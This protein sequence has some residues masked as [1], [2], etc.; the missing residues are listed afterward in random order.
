MSSNNFFYIFFAY[1]KVVMFLQLVIMNIIK[2]SYKRKPVKKN[3]VFLKEKHKKGNNM[4]VNDIKI[5][6][7]IKNRDLL[8][9]EKKM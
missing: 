9:I 3:K 4:V 6:Q 7:K 8:S 5:C 1:I 2:K